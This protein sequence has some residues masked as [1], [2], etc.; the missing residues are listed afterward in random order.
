MQTDILPQNCHADAMVIF[1]S[2]SQRVD[3]HRNIEPGP[4]ERVCDG[5]LIA[6]VRQ[7]TSSRQSHR[8]HHKM[9][10]GP[11]R[12]STLLTRSLKLTGVGAQRSR[13]EAVKLSVFFVLLVDGCSDVLRLAS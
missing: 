1:P 2:S 10:C 11:R 8:V 12:C 9:E 4:A 5:A 3:E 7:V 13:E 6:E